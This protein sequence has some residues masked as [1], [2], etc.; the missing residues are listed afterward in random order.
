MLQ[1]QL[2]AGP[3]RDLTRAL[4][5]KIVY[6]L[7]YRKNKYSFLPEL[8]DALNDDEKLISELFVRFSG[9]SI[10][11][12]TVDELEEIARDIRIYA[13]SRS[14]KIKD[15]AY[16]DLATEYGMPQETVR[17]IYIS[18]KKLLDEAGMG[19]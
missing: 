3:S 14:V 11:F 19:R 6:M 15:E 12:P 10:T 18:M 8:F 2:L 4:H 13:K 7:L 17:T 1:P 5:S 16:S 9:C